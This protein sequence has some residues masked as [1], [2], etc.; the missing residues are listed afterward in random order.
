MLVDNDGKLKISPPGLNPGERQFVD[1]LRRYWTEEQDN[2]PDDTEV[3]LL[4]NQG[5][6]AGI[7]F[8]ENS[9]F[10]PDFIL[11]IKSDACQRIVFIEPHGMRNQKV[12]AEDEKVRL[13]EQL[14]D[15]AREIAQ[16]SEASD[17]CLDSFII[18][19]TPYQELKPIYGTGDWSLDKFTKRH[20]LFPVRDNQYDYVKLILSD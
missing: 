2:M 17:V 16:R 14:P 9:G 13:H 20:I 19:Q 18:S 6:G 8:F 5:R 1:D 3:F 11:W 4:R 10:Y 7:G 12:Y 15:L